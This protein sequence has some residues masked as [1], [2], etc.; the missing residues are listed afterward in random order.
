MCIT[1]YRRTKIRGDQVPL[2]D[3]DPPPA[4]RLSGENLERRVMLD[5]VLARLSEGCRQII[6]YA[7]LQGYTRKEIGERLGVSEEAAR[8]K[9][10]RCIQA[11]RDLM[12][13][14]RTTKMDQA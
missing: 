2:E 6:V 13:G 4:S 5:Q 3:G 14:H 9:F 1:N 12:E 11:A 8:V 7:Y 10:C